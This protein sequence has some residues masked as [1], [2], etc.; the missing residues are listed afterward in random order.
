MASMFEG[1]ERDLRKKLV[2]LYEDFIE[3]PESE[4]ARE[5]AAAIA[6][7]YANSGD[8]NLSPKVSA[9]LYKTYDVELGNLSREEAKKILEELRKT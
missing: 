4:K 2:A 8:Y 6:Q 7:K 9:A 1:F 3:N 5:N